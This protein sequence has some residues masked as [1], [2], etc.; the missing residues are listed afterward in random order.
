MTANS[1]AIRGR[2]PD[3]VVLVDAHDTVLGTAGKL[4]AH[5]P[6]G[7]LHRAFSV[8]LFDGHGNLLLQRRAAGKHHFAR[9]WSNACCSHPSPGEDVLDAAARRCRE[10][11]GVPVADAVDVGTFVYRAH[12][13]VSGLVEHEL[14]H[15]VTAR[16]AG[17]VEPNPAEVSACRWV[18]PAEL[19]AWLG[20]GRAPVTPWLALAF[21]VVERS[22]RPGRGPG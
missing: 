19:R 12:D 21:D 2:D 5:R 1:G 17:P 16:A 15:V 3:R 22:A 11:L 20:T 4:D 13:P 6:P 18:T 7:R 9:C 10:E 8:F 14:D